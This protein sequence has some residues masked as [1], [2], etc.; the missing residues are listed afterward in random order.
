MKKLASW[1]TIFW[2]LVA[3]SQAPVSAQ[4]VS[5]SAS[6]EDATTVTPEKSKSNPPLKKEKP[7]E[8]P[9]KRNRSQ[10]SSKSEPGSP[11]DS[12]IAAAKS[13]GKVWVN[14]DSG[15]YHKN[16]R[17]YG[18]TKNGKFVTEAQAKA[19]GYKASQRN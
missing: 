3:I 17:W 4:A 8:Q 11:S 12:E 19:A 18:K 6:N 14:L 13:D 9:S 1:L 5:G 16:G 7:G 2:L 15:I 10:S